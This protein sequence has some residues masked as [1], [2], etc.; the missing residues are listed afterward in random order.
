MRLAP[1]H[2]QAIGDELAIRWND[3]TET[4]LPLEFLRRACPCAGCGGEP[5]VLGRVVRPEVTHT[6]ASFRLRSFQLVG[7]YAIQP[8]W[9]DGHSSGLY[10]YQ[11]LK[12]LE[13]AQGSP[14]A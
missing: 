14:A 12:R 10:T 4:Y 8:T 6:P 13:A 11:Y 5:D 2:V 3:G 7:G 1:E 9:E